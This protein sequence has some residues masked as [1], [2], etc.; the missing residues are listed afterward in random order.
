[1]NIGYAC[2]TVGVKDT[3]MKRCN[4]K[5]ASESRLKE[6]ISENLKSLENII[7][8]NIMNGIKL[9][10][11]SSDFIPFGSSPANSLKWWE[12]YD[13]KFM[14]IGNKIRDNDIRISMHPGQYTVLNSKDRSVVERAVDD[15]EYHSRVLD[16]LR[17]GPENKI[18]LHIGGV[19]KE[20]NRSIE[21]FI[22]NYQ[23]LSKPVRR[24][25]IIEN[26]DK[27]YNI[28]EVLEI[29]KR[30][31]AP[32]VFDNLHNLSN[33]SNPLKTEKFWI[34]ECRS[35]WQEKDGNQKIHYS[36]QAKDKRQGAHSK[37]INVGEF[38]KFYSSMERSDIDIMLEVKDKNL[39]AVKCINSIS[40]DKKIKVLESEWS[41]YKYS[42]LEKSP[43]NYNEIRE[44]LKDKRDYPV[45]RFYSI[46][47]TALNK[48][49]DVGNS[50]NAAMHVWGYFKKD[51]SASE[52]TKLMDKMGDY[53]DGK[54]SLRILK[55]SLLKLANKYE[56]KYLLES[57][58]FILQ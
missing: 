43:S 45:I 7:D 46:L 3:S 32:V 19:Y 28:S 26:D 49:E 12:I 11:I 31:G 21:R 1:M 56:I 51:V 25:L 44:L 50:I 41:K 4:K 35:T 40:M 30:I 58:Y 2:L 5:N 10:R 36:Q 57:Y 39:S 48:Q 13:E 20:K 42:V 33:P 6:L 27:S 37:S 24:R 38:L 29:G 8:Y 9:F 18:V 34:N 16:S 54:I 53:R 14:H 22:E 52:K 17:A 55:G 23:L 47:E 15:L